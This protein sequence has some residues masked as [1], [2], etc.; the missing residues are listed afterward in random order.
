[1]SDNAFWRFMNPGP[2]NMQVLILGDK[3]YHVNGKFSKENVGILIMAAAST[4]G[5]LAS[6]SN[7]LYFGVN[8]IRESQY[9]CR[10]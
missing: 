2:F 5:A 1:M 10:G 7:Y 8:L 9:F 4:H 3:V 6:E